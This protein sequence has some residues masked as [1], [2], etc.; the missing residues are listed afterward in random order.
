[1]FT[2]HYVPED[3]ANTHKQIQTTSISLWMSNSAAD[4]ATP[5]KRTTPHSRAAAHV[6]PRLVLH[7]VPHSRHTFARRAWGWA[8][9]APRGPLR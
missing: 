3:D 4:T 2:G 7:P 5:T 6:G 1:V 8:S 9:R